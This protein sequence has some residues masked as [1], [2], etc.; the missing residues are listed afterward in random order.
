MKILNRSA[1]ILNSDSSK[2][3]KFFTDSYTNF[4][5]IVNKIPDPVEVFDARSSVNNSYYE[6]S[7]PSS[8]V[9]SNSRDSGSV[10]NTTTKSQISSATKI[11][12]KALDKQGRSIEDISKMEQQNDIVE[13]QTTNDETL[14]SRK[15][16][17]ATNATSFYSV[18]S[19]SSTSLVATEIS[20]DLFVEKASDSVDRSTISSPKSRSFAIKKYLL[21]DFIA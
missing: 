3:D 10:A 2:K 1:Q 11:I 15:I 4:E 17:N 12:G 14:A 20:E 6:Q 13:D 7:L 21:L 19:G 5:E 18:S 9:C 16:S 8:V